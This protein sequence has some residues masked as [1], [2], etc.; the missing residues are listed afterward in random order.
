MSPSLARRVRRLIHDQE[1]ECDLRHRL[2]RYGLAHATAFSDRAWSSLATQLP[3]RPNVLIAS[4]VSV[5]PAGRLVPPLGMPHHNRRL[6]RT[7]VGCQDCDPT[8]HSKLQLLRGAGLDA[9]V[10]SRRQRALHSL[11]PVS[12]R[13]APGSR[14]MPYTNS[15]FPIR[16]ITP[17]TIIIEQA[18]GR[19]QLFAHRLAGTRSSQL[20]L[21][22]D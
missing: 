3:N 6:L 19:D 14:H 11:H 2:R 9:V 16:L 10:M 4:A 8:E 7:R 12:L 5:D 22:F 18:F 15:Y 21:A 13:L 1:W 20:T 17:F